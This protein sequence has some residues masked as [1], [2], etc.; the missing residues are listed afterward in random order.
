MGGVSREKQ[1]TGRWH[2]RRPRK[3]WG[4]GSLTRAWPVHPGR[5]HPP[6]RLRRRMMEPPP[7]PC[8]VPLRHAGVMLITLLVFA[9]A[10]TSGP[11]VRPE[12][13]ERRG[14]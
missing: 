8:F 3:P 6:G 2:V 11:E 12:A 4:S 9:F 10:V 1:H 7:A 5:S 14:L 13:A